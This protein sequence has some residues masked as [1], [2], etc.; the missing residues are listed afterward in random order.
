M[1]SANLLFNKIL[2]AKKITPLRDYVVVKPLSREETTASGIVIPDTVKGETPQEG[3]ILFAGP[4]KMDE[5]GKRIPMEVKVGD[6][7][8]FSNLYG[9]EIKIDGEEYLMMNENDIKAIIS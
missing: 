4:G 5:N 7:I 6:K 1:M 2:M 9:G 3:E 8:L